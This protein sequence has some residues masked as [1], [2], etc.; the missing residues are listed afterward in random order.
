MVNVID[1]DELAEWD[2]IY[3]KGVMHRYQ[4][5]IKVAAQGFFVMDRRTGYRV[6]EHSRQ[7]ICWEWILDRE[8][9]LNELI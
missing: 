4:Y 2:D 1:W 8:K 5:G 6:F 3:P 7:D 9:E